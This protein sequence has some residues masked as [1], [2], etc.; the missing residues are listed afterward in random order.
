MSHSPE[1]RHTYRPTVKH[2]LGTPTLRRGTICPMIKHS[3]HKIVALRIERGWKPSELA[4]RAGIKQP[5]LWALENGVTK[6]PKFE[7][8]KSIA[9]ALGVPIQA[10]T[11]DE[12]DPDIDSRIAAAIAALQPANKNAMLA[13]AEALLKSQKPKGK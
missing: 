10:I 9:A 3:P 6:M 13:A 2:F 11:A 7:T 8:I 1:F 5:S 12:A 4:R